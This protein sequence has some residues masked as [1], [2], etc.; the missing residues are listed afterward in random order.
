MSTLDLPRTASPHV[1]VQQWG[2]DA[3]PSIDEDEEQPAMALAMPQPVFLPG[4]PVPETRADRPTPR[5]ALLDRDNFVSMRGAVLNLEP[6]AHDFVSM[7]G[8]VLEPPAEAI[9][10]PASLVI[11]G[12]FSL[13]GELMHA[14]VSYRVT[15]EGPA[16]NKLSG[17][18]AEKIRALSTDS[19]HQLH[20]PRHGWGI[21]P[22]T[23]KQPVPFRQ[24]EAKVHH[25]RVGISDNSLSGVIGWGPIWSLMGYIGWSADM[26]NLHIGWGLQGVEHPGVELRANLKSIYHRC[27]LFEMALA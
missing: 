25:P 5:G 26:S 16:G 14:F 4:T 17:R 20:I 3:V 22:R 23:A 18:L 13:R 24:E 6:P 15:T 21:W 10:I 19:R 1:P 27:H 8:A 11:R 12:Q 7:R 9:N 2:W